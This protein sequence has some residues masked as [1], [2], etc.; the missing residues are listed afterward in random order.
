MESQ[1]WHCSD[2]GDERE[3]VQ[4]TCSDGHAESGAECPEWICAECGTAVLVGGAHVVVLPQVRR[5]A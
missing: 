5:A 4:P 2:C 1:L 3:F